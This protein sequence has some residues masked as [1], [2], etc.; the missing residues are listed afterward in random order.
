MWGDSEDAVSRTH[1][2]INVRS[3]KMSDVS[4]DPFYLSLRDSLCPISFLKVDPLH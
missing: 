4:L 2:K 1:R 3:L